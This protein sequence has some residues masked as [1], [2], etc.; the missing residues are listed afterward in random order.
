[1]I[2]H[3]KIFSSII[4]LMAGMFSLLFT[5]QAYKSFP[6]R[7]LKT[8]FYYFV[9][10][11]C[12]EFVIISMKY[13][14]LNIYDSSTMNI[15][16]V[17]S[18]AFYLILSATFIGR[19]VT[20]V[21]MVSGLLNG[22][23]VPLVKKWALPVVI[24]GVLV[25]VIDIMFFETDMELSLF[26]ILMYTSAFV[27]FFEVPA[28]IFMIYKA[29]RAADNQYQKMLIILAS[30][31]LI[32]YV[33]LPG[34]HYLPEPINLFGGRITFL[35]TNLIPLIWIKFYFLDYAKAQAKGKRYE[36]VLAEI[37]EKYSIS[38]RE[39]EILKLILDGNSNREIKTKLF[40]SYHTV[41]N[42]VYNLFQKLGVKSRYE[43]MHFLQE[44]NP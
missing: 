9:F 24:L 12:F 19:T 29:R 4:F 25:V 35:Y 1:M 15:S 14:H 32:R 34:S 37:V 7:Y 8:L 42:H 40:I 20:M 33:L 5:Y 31:F 3:L 30:L 41:K 10:Y 27:Y 6:Y 2:P 38:K 18:N 22:V 17:L 13:F 28:L 36:N 43:L 23:L 44:R 26:Q 11:N 21:Q 39:L 16:P